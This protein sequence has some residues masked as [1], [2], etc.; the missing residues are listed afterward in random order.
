M[1]IPVDPHSSAA[2]L[3]DSFP[4]IATL[5]ISPSEEMLVAATDHR[6]L[7]GITLLPVGAGRGRSIF[8][9]S[10]KALSCVAW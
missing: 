9:G 6:Q 7:Y 5:T 4:A 3:N 8:L 2:N 10:S 1:Q